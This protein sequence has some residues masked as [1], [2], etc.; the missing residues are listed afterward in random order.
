MRVE[1]I[2]GASDGIRVEYHPADKRAN[3]FLSMEKGCNAFYVFAE[4]ASIA[5]GYVFQVTGYKRLGVP[6]KTKVWKFIDC[7]NNLSFKREFRT[8]YAATVEL[9]KIWRR[10]QQLECNVTF[11]NDDLQA[12]REWARKIIGD[13]PIGASKIQRDLIETAKS[14]DVTMRAAIS[15][16][17]ELK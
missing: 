2:G 7:N 1:M 11:E 13:V 8:R 3:E 4:S 9:I 17:L 6:K 15:Q 12:W 5:I 16:T 14:D 10:Q